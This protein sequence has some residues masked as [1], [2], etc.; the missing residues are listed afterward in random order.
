MSVCIDCASCVRQNSSDCD[1]CI[2]TFITRP[3]TSEA[4]VIDF[5]DYAALKRLQSA[6]M[7]PKLRHRTG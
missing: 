4:V 1:D 2:V 7:V 5:E 3:Q 6:G